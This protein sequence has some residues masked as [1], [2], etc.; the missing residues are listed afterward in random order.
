MTDETTTT[1]P[2]AASMPDDIA[3]SSATVGKIAEALSKA[4]KAIQRPER[5]GH[6]DVRSRK[7]QAASFKYDYI[8]LEDL[9]DALVKPFADNALAWVQ[10]TFPINGK[11]CIVTTLMHSSGEWLRGIYPLPGAMTNQ[12]MGGNMTYGKRYALSGMVGVSC[13]SDNDGSKTLAPESEPP[14]EPVDD[15]KREALTAAASEG[16]LKLANSGKI[17]E[18]DE[19][20]IRMGDE[21]A[22]ESDK[23]DPKLAK[24]LAAEQITQQQLIEYYVSAGHFPDTMMPE[25]L[26]QDYIKALIKPANWKKAAQKMRGN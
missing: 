2:P 8:L 1:T 17:I 26:P 6:A 10:A 16:R 19:D 14:V 12:D 24:A 11:P 20:S 3:L 4:R 9:E 7:G 23:L 13:E 5:R 25:N 18:P 15:G 22:E 21:P